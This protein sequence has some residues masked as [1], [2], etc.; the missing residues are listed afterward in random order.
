MISSPDMPVLYPQDITIS[1]PIGC[2]PFYLR[3]LLSNHFIISFGYNKSDIP[4]II[5]IKTNILCRAPH[6]HNAAVNSENTINRISPYNLNKQI[7][8]YRDASFVGSNYSKNRKTSID[9]GRW[10]EK[11]RSRTLF[12]SYEDFHRFG[13]FPCGKNGL[14][15]FDSCMP[16][17]AGAELFSSILFSAGH[18]TNKKPRKGLTGKC[19]CYF[20]TFSYPKNMNYLSL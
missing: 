8:I 16:L 15:S 9:A 18:Q 17:V 4:L 3:F 10:K 5:H 1:K 6:N 13:N 7:L 11:Q 19:P 12:L 2:L 14:S 20:P